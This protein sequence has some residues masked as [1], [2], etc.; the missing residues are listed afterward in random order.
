[1]Q[2]IVLFPRRVLCVPVRKLKRDRWKFVV[3][4]R[5]RHRQFDIYALQSFSWTLPAYKSFKRSAL[6][7][8]GR[9]WTA[10]DRSPVS[11]QD[12]GCLAALLTAQGPIQPV[13]YSNVSAPGTI[14]QAVVTECYGR[15]S[16]RAEFTSHSTQHLI[17]HFRPTTDFITGWHL[18]PINESFCWRLPPLLEGTKVSSSLSPGPSSSSGPILSLQIWR[19]KPVGLL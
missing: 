18:F 5:L 14:F 6:L 3:F 12:D 4:G 19:S 16:E 9:V 15:M 11:W 17:V 10:P 13:Q 2:R 8:P 1:M 7:S